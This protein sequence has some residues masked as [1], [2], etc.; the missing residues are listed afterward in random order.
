MI[1]PPCPST[2]APPP[3][4]V[5]FLTTK[6]VVRKNQ[7]NSGQMGSCAWTRQCL[8]IRGSMVGADRLNVPAIDT[9]SH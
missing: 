8:R 7:D 1:Q 9:F 2:I 3:S 6:I 4:H 5:I